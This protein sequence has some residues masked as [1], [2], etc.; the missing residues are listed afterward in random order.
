MQQDKKYTPRNGHQPIAQLSKNILENIAKQNGLSDFN[1]FLE[2]NS[3][4]GE[5]F[6]KLAHPKKIT[7]PPNKKNHGV[8]HIKTTSYGVTLVQH[9]KEQLISKINTYFGY[10]AVSDIRVTIWP[11]KKTIENRVLLE[12]KHPISVQN[13]SLADSIETPGLKKALLDLILHKP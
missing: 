4:V 6:G 3:I 9:S 7:F 13:L 10:K 5:Y 2:W 12:Q 11:K 1:L 8:L